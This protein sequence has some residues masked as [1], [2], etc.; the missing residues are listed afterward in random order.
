MI[1]RTAE[2]A[3]MLVNQVTYLGQFGY[4]NSLCTYQ[5]EYYL[6][7]FEF[8]ERY[9]HAFV[10]KFSDRCFCLITAAILVPIWVGTSTSSS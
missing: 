9:I 7:V 3:V 10:A 4:Q 8:L 5:K 2:R 1:Y 6:N